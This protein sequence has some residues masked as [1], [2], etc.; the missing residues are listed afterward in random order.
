MTEP[1]TSRYR[2][3]RNDE[4]RLEQVGSRVELSGWV[5]RKRDHGNLLFVDLRD[6]YGVTQIVF[7]PNSEAFT[8]AEVLRLESVIKVTGKVIARTEENVNPLLVT[9]QI[10]VAAERLEVLSV[11]ETLPF[12]VAGTQEIPEEQRLRYR[13]LGLLQFAEEARGLRL[14]LGQ[15]GGRGPQTLV[16]PDRRPPANVFAL[17]GANG[18]PFYGPDPCG[19][20][21][22]LPNDVCHGAL[23]QLSRHCKNWLQGEAIA[24][25][26]KNRVS[27]MLAY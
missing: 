5:H 9:G 4:L 3:H 6:H 2:T 11:A 8:A 7:T 23:Q 12:Q 21:A 25:N 13:L 24:G 19:G 1:R 16:H 17:D 27:P 26:P 22:V 15:V 18:L 14:G 20:W 10:E